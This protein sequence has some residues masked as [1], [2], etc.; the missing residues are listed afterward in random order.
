MPLHPARERA[1]G[2]NQVARVLEACPD[3]HALIRADLLQRTIHRVEQKTLNRTRREQNVAHSFTVPVHARADMTDAH[4][5]LIDDICATGATVRE[6]ARTCSE[7]G[8]ASVTILVFCN[9]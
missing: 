2:Y 5:L 1:R 9:S 8:A 3:T 4:I 6:A 7:A